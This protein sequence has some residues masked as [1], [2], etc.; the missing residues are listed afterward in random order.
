MFAAS[1]L[2]ICIKIDIMPT[3]YIEL[4]KFVFIVSFSLGAWTCIN[5]LINRR[6]DYYI[7][8]A[9]ITYVLVLM[10]APINAYVNLIHSGE[11]YFLSLLSQKLTWIYGPLLMILID[12]LLLKRINSRNLMWHFLPFIFFT[13]HEVL[14]LQW[15]K[16]WQHLF[17][18]YLQ[19][20]GYLGYALKN[21]LKYKEQFKKLNKSYRSS[22]YYWAMHL[23]FGLVIVMVW[24][25]I[26]VN[27]L[28]FEL[29]SSLT[30]TTILASFFAIYIS[31][32]SLLFVYQSGMSD[33]DGK[34]EQSEKKDEKKEK[35]EK[36][37]KDEQG[38][39]FKE[40]IINQAEVGDS[41][42]QKAKVTPNLRSIELSPEAAS[43]LQQRLEALIKTHQ[44]HLDETISLGK[45]AS[46]LGI[47]PHQLSELFNI[48]M[49][50]SFYDYLN[51]LRYEESI[52]LLQDT[53][54]ACSITDIAYRSGFNNRNSFY[55]VFKEKTGLTP[56][57]FKNSLSG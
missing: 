37:E 57:Q 53:R 39:F 50:T 5:L 44:P 41:A 7:R 13:L 31:A 4:F 23:S 42:R 1:P 24:D 40:Q 38:K 27:G 45:L 48:H 46:L 9:L 22:S 36:R 15:I 21:I 33:E 12:R 30:F 34:D 26:I 56:T 52:R 55:K 35:D 10:I 18:L 54:Q 14:Q 25:L 16:P 47:T 28:F 29:I 3:F 20:G 32:L 6:T 11:I 43:D 49:S 8:R 19:I 51:H 17:I 2:F